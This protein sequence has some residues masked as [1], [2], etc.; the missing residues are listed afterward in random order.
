METIG[1]DGS[2]SG[3]VMKEKHKSTTSIGASLT[4]D[5]REK[6]ESNNTSR[7]SFKLRRFCTEV[8]LS[9][10]VMSGYLR[11]PPDQL[12][13]FCHCVAGICAHGSNIM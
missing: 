1:G 7:G 3:L 13:C 2:K 12:T 6:E 8:A 5:Y 10:G 9:I 4:P 11:Q